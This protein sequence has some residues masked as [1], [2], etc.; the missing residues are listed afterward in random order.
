MSNST[1]EKISHPPFRVHRRVMLLCLLVA[2][3]VLTNIATYLSLEDRLYDTQQLALK[4]LEDVKAG[5]D[6][7]PRAIPRSDGSTVDETA[8]LRPFEVI[9]GHDHLYKLEH[10]DKYLQA[11]ARTGVT[12]TLFVASNDYTFK[13]QGGDKTALTEWSSAEILRAAQQFPGKIIPFCTI[14]TEDPDKLKKIKE[15]VREGAVGLKL[16]NGHSTYYTK[17]LDSPHM[18]EVFAYCERIGLPICWHVNTARYAG[19]FVN[20]M[21]RH[22]NL[23]VIV[24]HFGVTFYQPQSAAWKATLAMLDKYPNLY[25]DSS[26][27][28]RDFLVHGL[29]MV[30]QHTDIFKNAFLKYQ[31]RIIFGT[32]MVVTGNR[33]K[34]SEWCESVIR[35]CRDMLEKDE[36]HFWMAATGAATAYAPAKN[37]YGALRGMN[38][39]DEVLKK[40]YQTNLEGILAKPI[41]PG[42]E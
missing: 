25:V 34:T 4:A 3:L 30:T 42:A 6:F 28:T 32:D 21:D 35:A 15:Y 17:P 14:F 41:N 37:H 10:L 39:P 26:F 36:Y 12:K 1:K 7:T 11:A 31:D 9:N 2:A 33:E 19:E 23:T 38:L 20:V 22:P 16:Y 5:Q 24:P 8:P 27:G 13:G 18:E 29:E 40:I